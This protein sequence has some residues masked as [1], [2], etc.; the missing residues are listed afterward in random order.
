MQSVQ[1][2]WMQIAERPTLGP[3]VTNTIWKTV[4]KARG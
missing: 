1:N 2:K 4:P 3:Q